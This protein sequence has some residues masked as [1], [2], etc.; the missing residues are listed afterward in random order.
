MQ[1]ITKSPGTQSPVFVIEV[2]LDTHG[3]IFLQLC[4]RWQELHKRQRVRVMI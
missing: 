3:D 4:E 2:T 1:Q